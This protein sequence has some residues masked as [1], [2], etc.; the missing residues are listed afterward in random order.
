M[1]GSGRSA[2]IAGKLDDA[3]GGIKVIKS[4]ILSYNQ[5]IKSLSYV[6]IEETLLTDAPLVPGREMAAKGD[7]NF[8]FGFAATSSGAVQVPELAADLR[9]R[10]TPVEVKSN[11]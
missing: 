3:V 8:G 2:R 4:H 5:Q 6:T 9:K 10:M 7:F 11:N 1:A